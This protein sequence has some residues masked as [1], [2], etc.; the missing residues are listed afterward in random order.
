MGN[1]VQNSRSGSVIRDHEILGD[2]AVTSHEEAVHLG[3]LTPEEKV[4]EKKLRR[5]IDML[6]MP[7]VVLVYLMNYIDRNNYAA[8]RLQ[9]LEKDL[10]LT[11][12]QYQ[13]GKGCS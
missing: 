12:A 7:C 4:L 11:P 6:I 3:E 10:K 1:S 5:K 13:T 2:K 9:D 8:A